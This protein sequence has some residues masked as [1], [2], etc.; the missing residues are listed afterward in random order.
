MK[1]SYLFIAALAG[2]LLM[3]SCAKNPFGSA[4]GQEY[5]S[6]MSCGF[7]QNVYGERIS[8]KGKLPIT[9]YIHEDMP[10]EF[11]PVVQSAMEKWEKAAGRRLF[12][13][14]STKYTGPIRPRQDGKNIIYWMTNW[15]GDRQRE[16]GRTSVYWIGDE[17]KESDIRINAKDF[18]Y[19]VSEPEAFR[20]VH[21]E[22][23]MIHELG[24]VLGLKHADESTD[25][26]MGAYLSASLTRDALSEVDASA[27]LCEYKL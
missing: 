1:T 27:L 26:V 9:F 14:V 19:F 4:F 20:D 18:N 12:D 24:H 11:I 15:E 22:S 21:F 7:V 8:W 25:S 10:A 23:L 3:G 6:E 2:A 5:T 17:I 13:L 16:Q